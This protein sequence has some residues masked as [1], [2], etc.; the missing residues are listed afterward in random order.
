MILRFN[1]GER[2]NLS[3]HFNV[4][5]FQCPCDY[6]DCKE[7]KIDQDLIAKLEKMREEAGPLRI[8][9]GFRCQHYQDELRA[10]GYETSAGISQHT[11]GRASDVMRADEGSVGLELEKIARKAGFKAVGV[12]SSFIHVDLRD[13]KERRWEYKA[14]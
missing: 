2:V 8:N 6:E 9:S 7:T 1:K 3:K 13:D 5:E 10:R 14:R 11:L 4:R 12:G